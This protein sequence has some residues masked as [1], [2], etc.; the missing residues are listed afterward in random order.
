M[1]IRYVWKTV[2]SDMAGEDSQLLMEA[3]KV[4]IIEMKFDRVASVESSIHDTLVREPRQPQLTPRLKA[5]GR[6]IAAQGLKPARIRMGMTKRYGISEAE[7]P[8]LRQAQWFISH[9]A[10]KTLNRNDDHDG[11]LDQND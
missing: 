4:F 11:I 9:Y 3:M 5:Y 10:K 7:M 6:E 2:C 1:T 8:T